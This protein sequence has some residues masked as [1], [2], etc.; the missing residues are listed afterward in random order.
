MTSTQ[1]PIRFHRLNSKRMDRTRLRVRAISSNSRQ[2]TNAGFSGPIH[3]N[4]CGIVRHRPISAVSHRLLHL[5]LESTNLAAIL[6]PLFSRILNASSN[7][8]EKL[9]TRLGRGERRYMNNVAKPST[10]LKQSLGSM[11]ILP[12]KGMVTVLTSQ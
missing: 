10:K 5:S 6:N 3:R 12:P 4:K 7:S 11:M 9:I 8:A 2:I 1:E